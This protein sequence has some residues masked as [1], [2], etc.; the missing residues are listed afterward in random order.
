MF[1]WDYDP[2]R[3][4]HTGKYYISI[5]PTD[6]KWLFFDNSGWGIG[7][8]NSITIEDAENNQTVIRLPHIEGLKEWHQDYLSHINGG[9]YDWNGWNRRGHALAK[10]VAKALPDSVAL[11]YPYGDFV[12]L[13][14]S[15]LGERCYIKRL[16]EEI[17]I[18]PNE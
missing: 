18:D 17:W 13:E 9:I 10:A 11:Y 5:D 16:K 15:T 8:E 6:E 3:C 1:D 4:L 14:R 2:R 7:N 12:Q